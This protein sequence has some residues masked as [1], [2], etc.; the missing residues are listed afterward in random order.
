MTKVEEQRYSVDQETLKQ[1]FPLHKVTEGLFEIYQHLLGLDFVEIDNPEVW[2]EGVQ[3][4]SL[5][6]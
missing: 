6:I 4:V 3:L 1:Y 2:A 5:K